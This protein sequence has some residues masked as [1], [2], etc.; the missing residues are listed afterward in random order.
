M[1]DSER[2][3]QGASPLNDLERL[4][5]DSRAGR[6][7]VE[8]L[9]RAL[10]AADLY[11]PSAT[12]IKEDG[13]GFA[14]LLFDNL[15]GNPLAAVFTDP[16]RAKAHA[17]RAKYLLQINGRELFRRL[18]AGYGIVINPGH[19]LGM[20]IQPYGVEAIVRDFT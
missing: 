3:E 6:A 10:V 4:L 8:G 11:V 17:S 19:R 15:N 1:E 13:S 20:E 5:L 12:E 14:P 18:P 7:T 16:E 9:L 2:D